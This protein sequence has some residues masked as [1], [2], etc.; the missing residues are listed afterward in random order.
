MKDYVAPYSLLTRQMVEYAALDPE[1]EVCGLVYGQ[2]VLSINNRAKD[3][4][5][6]FVLDEEELVAAYTDFGAPD[7]V[8][9]SHP[10]GDPNPSTADWEGLPPGAKM[11]IVAGGAVYVYDEP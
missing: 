8:W 4:S 6:F 11:Y 7:G 2:A 10:N 9:H 3:P 1:V 5:A